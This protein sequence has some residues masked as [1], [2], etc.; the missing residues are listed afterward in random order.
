MSLSAPSTGAEA[1]LSDLPSGAQPALTGTLTPPVIE[2]SEEPGVSVSVDAAA[3]GAL[4]SDT[5]APQ[6]RA[7]EDVPDVRISAPIP[8]E[9]PNTE[10]VQERFPNGSLK[11][12]R[13]VTQDG[14][15][16]FINHGSWKEWNAQGELIAE[17]EFKF[18]VRHGV[19]RRVLR[20]NESPLFNTPPYNQYKGPFISEAHLEN[21]RLQGTW[22]VADA[23]GRKISEIE[24]TGGA[25]HGLAS[26][27][28]SNGR[29][30]QQINFIKGVAGEDI[31]TW[32]ADG[33]LAA[34]ETYLE[35]RKVETK[36]E[37]YAQ[38]R[39]KSLGDFLLPRMVVT[40]EDDWWNC[41]LATFSAD[42]QPDRHGPWTAWHPNGQVQ[43]QGRFKFGQPEGEFTWYY[44]NGQKS[45]EGS[46]RNGERHGAWTWW[47]NNGLKSSTGE[48][49]DG[50]PA[51]QWT[52]WNPEGKVAQKAD[53]ADGVPVHALEG[54]PG[55][56]PV[57][58]SNQAR[59]ISPYH[60]R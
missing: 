46:Y 38:G 36:T 11:I 47:H 41:R 37:N 17:G 23:L 13:E 53:F 42:G 25:R 52:W 45:A 27:W 8:A 54:R 29:K 4:P 50:K 24:F 40:K 7:L 49:V 15:G 22:I 35:G 19:W 18:G 51:G 16:N 26:W 43:V 20:T 3:P 10:M 1:H 6:L 5:G 28:H 55:I 9:A 14:Q 57:R 59:A 12:A 30:M 2:A 58:G 39:R 44:S 60:R 32:R 48:F 56:A 21:G 33:S 34:K 31:L